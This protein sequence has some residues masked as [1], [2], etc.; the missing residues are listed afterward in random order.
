MEEYG[1]CLQT[2]IPIRNNPSESS[3]MV[4][5]LLF[6]ES[7]KVLQANDKWIEIEI[8]LDH[9]KGWLDAKLHESI[10]KDKRFQDPQIISSALNAITKNGKKQLLL[11][12][13]EI[14]KNDKTLIL[15]NYTFEFPC[16]NPL[17]RLPINLTSLAKEYIN[18]PYL[19]GGKSILGIDCSGLIQVIFKVFGIDL[20]RDASQQVN[21][22][23]TVGFINEAQAGDLAFFDNVDGNITHVGLL[24][25]NTEIIHASGCVRIDKIDH[26]GIFLSKN[27][28]YSHKLRIIKRIL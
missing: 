16:I 13:S 18:A 3:E 1:I 4:T 10:D 22:G 28:S 2:L 6:G 7:Y 14:P 25:S 21:I 19:W 11:A 20:P 17:K 9:Y 12:G 8:Q 23:N 15:H 26:Q 5:Q 27:N 24:L